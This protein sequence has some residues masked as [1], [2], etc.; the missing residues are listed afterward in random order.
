MKKDEL[1]EQ[2]F[3]DDAAIPSITI[4]C[5]GPAPPEDMVSFAPGYKKLDNKEQRRKEVQEAM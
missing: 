1:G 3:E 4:F 2:F 5:Y